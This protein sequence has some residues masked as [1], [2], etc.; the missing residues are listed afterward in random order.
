[1]I[2]SRLAASAAGLGMLLASPVAAQVLPGGHHNN[3]NNTAGYQA[4]VRMEA[5]ALTGRWAAAFIRDDAER[6][7]AM[8][9]K[10]AVMLGSD[11]AVVR[12]RKSIGES[13]R[14]AVPLLDGVQMTVDDFDL[15]GEIVYIAGR[16]TY[17][18]EQRGGGILRQVGPFSM[19]LRRDF[20]TS[21]WMIRS[22][23]TPGPLVQSDDIAATQ[24]GSAPMPVGPSEPIAPRTAAP[25]DSANA[26]L[27]RQAAIHYEKARAA[28]RVDDWT[29]Y[30]SEMQ[31]LGELLRKVEAERVG[32]LN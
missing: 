9:T 6:L 1:M 15:S 30:G 10:D 29:T 31:K 16:F 23:M 13:L 7:A 2:L 32:G 20:D 4:Q 14:R 24:V 26:N 18:V 22:H 25:A 28:Q 5:M 17:D 8:Y 19:V 3:T 27:L 21:D 12:S 11:G